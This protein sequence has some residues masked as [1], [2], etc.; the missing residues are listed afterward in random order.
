M[1]DPRFPAGNVSVP[2]SDVIVYADVFPENIVAPA[3]VIPCNEQYRHTRVAK[4]RERRERAK[5]AARDYR[6]PLE[7]EVEKI[8][9][10]DERSSAACQ[11]PQE[12]DELSLDVERRDAKVRIGYYIA[13]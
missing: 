4:I 13:R 9:V 1:V 11:S 5:A 8:S 6:F 3:V 10:D 12:S 7:P 2:R